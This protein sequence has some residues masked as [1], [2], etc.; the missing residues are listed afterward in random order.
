MNISFF[1]LVVLLLCLFDR[2]VFA[3]DAETSQNISRQF[4]PQKDLIHPGDVIDV[5]ILGSVEYDWRG[6]LSPE[7]FLNGLDFIEE[8]VFALC[9]TEKE[10][11]ADIARGYSKL[12][13]DPQVVVRIVDRTKRPDATI[14]GAVKKEQRFQI[15]RPVLLSELI[16]LAGGLT[17]QA[18][19]EIQ[20]FRPRSLNCVEVYNQRQ[21]TVAAG[22]ERERFVQTSQDTG[23]ELIKIKVSDLLKGNENANPQIFSGDIITILEADPIYVIGGVAAPKRLS[24]RTQTTLSRAIAGAGGFTKDAEPEN[25]TIFRRTAGET[26]I[27][28]VN[29]REIEK[30][31]EKDILLKPFDVV[32]VGVRGRG[33][34][35]LP[36][37]LGD[38]E[39]A[40]RNS[41]KLP[42]RIID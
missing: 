35:K 22:G 16:V 7:G 8:P 41:E 29:Y 34:S 17:D 6:T 31:A 30:N 28:E 23:S 40:S 27:I 32:D 9:R 12:L 4:D 1:I 38:D 33:K 3:Q 39:T 5:D 19:G 11:A 24:S 13:R 10:V 15:R 18:S 2:I 21:K 14:F 26:E 37:V 20:I 25:I 42:L 36:P